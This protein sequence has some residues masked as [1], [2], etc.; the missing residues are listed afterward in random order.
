MASTPFD[1]SVLS[2][3][4]Q[5]AIGGRRVRAAVFLT[6]R[7]DPGFFETEI[8]PVL[9][10][11]SLSHA[12]EV[13]LLQLEERVREMRTPV[14]VYYDRVALDAN[15][16]SSML[17]HRVGLTATT[18]YF[19]PKNV[20]LLLDP[21]DDARE[22]VPSLLVGTMSAN[23]TRAGWWENIEVAH[24]EEIPERSACTFRNDLL[25]L[26]GR[27]KSL[28]PEGT[29]HATLD[30]IHSFVLNLLQDDTRKR[31]GQLQTRI[32]AG[33]ESLPDFLD[34]VAGKELRGCNLEVI[35]PY[36]DSSN[37]TAPL[38][39]LQAKF[40]L[41]DVRILLPRNPDDS[42]A[43][44]ESIY[45]KFEELG[46]VWGELPGSLTTMGNHA[47]RTVHA[48]VY[49][50]FNPDSKA[51][52]VVGGSVNFTRPGFHG[53]QN[54]ESGIFLDR[55]NRLRPNWWLLD[56]VKRPAVFNVEADPVDSAAQATTR[57]CIRFHWAD[58]NSAECYWDA[59]DASP[60]L[61]IFSQAGLLFEL[62]PLQPRTWTPL[63]PEHVTLLEQLLTSTSFLKVA[64]GDGEKAVILVEETGIE[65]RPSLA[66]SLTSDEILRYW[67]LLSDSQKRAFLEEHIAPTAED[68]TLVVELRERFQ[69]E[70]DRSFFSSFAA[71]FQSF[72]NLHKRV[73]DA[74]ADNRVDQAVSFLFALRYD[75][76]ATLIEKILAE[77]A[78]APEMA[79]PD[80]VNRYI[81][82][83]C[84]KQLLERLRTEQP[85]FAR[86]HRE[87]FAK[88]Q[89][90]LEGLGE[91]R[92]QLAFGSAEE[93]AHFLDWFE[94]RFL[95]VARPKEATA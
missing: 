78:A 87:S 21:R 19:H 27:I 93:R 83:L 67:A 16:R 5:E 26:I 89:A 51:E 52:F 18:G 11:V 13:R 42:A 54:V 92:E 25:R 34:S 50:F 4:L 9:F 12:E 81:K 35:S 62:G 44:T 84:A 23:L 45:A 73:S 76:L 33:V 64:E 74:I 39:Q 2:E 47:G 86:S 56:K 7:F 20:L 36:F 17:T 72:S 37:S 8:L 38:E 48:K 30:A 85:E 57:L 68:R 82:L 63:S 40:K 55:T 10:D 91:A 3:A 60:R 66:R 59:K 53:K 46:V 77:G 70:A 71:I 88:L 1:T 80:P 29:P 79:P 94:P 32:Y 69:R 75:S 43:C 58:T 24:F 31:G 61:R 15:K 41:G 90:Q 14:T 95:K 65:R 28:A 6:F 22:D 49:H